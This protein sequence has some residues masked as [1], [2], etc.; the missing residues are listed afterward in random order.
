MKKLLAVLMSVMLM[1]L[2]VPG[3]CEDTVDIKIA[4]WTSNADQLALLGSFVDEFAA[5]KGI[6]IN[7]T[8]ESLSGA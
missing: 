5:E 2:V 3:L 4:T 6:K 7:C 8:F 1:A